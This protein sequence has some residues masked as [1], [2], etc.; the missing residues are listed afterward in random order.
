MEL[1]K[2]FGCLFGGL[3]F[4]F[5]SAFYDFPVWV[6]SSGDGNG[7]KTVVTV[8][9]K[10]QQIILKEIEK[11][12]SKEWQLNEESKIH[13]RAI[14]IKPK[15]L[16][17]NRNAL[18]EKGIIPKPPEGS[19]NQTI[20]KAIKDNAKPM[21]A[22]ELFESKIPSSREKTSEE[23]PLWNSSSALPDWVKEEMEK[24]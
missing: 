23:K 24:L 16:E 18:I 10:E 3:P 4:I 22:Q 1:Q 9:E 12:E 20:S 17:I 21:S 11:I 13:I 14:S 19:K 15:M 6:F 2:T 8:S 5:K 7:T